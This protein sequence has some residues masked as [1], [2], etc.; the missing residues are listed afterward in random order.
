MARLDGKTALITGGG[1]GIGKATALLFS[2]EGA[3]V[4][5]MS[6]TA[7]RLDE[8]VAENPG[9]GEIK[10]YPGDVSVEEDVKRVVEAFYGDFGSVDILFNNAG[11]LEGGTVVTTSNEVWDRTI[12]INV[13]G[14]FLVSKHVVPLMAKHGGGSIINNSSVLGIV[15]ME[16]CVAYNASKGAVRQITRSMALDHAKDNIR[17]NS[18]CPGYIKTK[19]DPEFMGNPPDAEEQLDAI[20]AD[21]IP[22]VRRAE[23]E[24]VAHSVLYLAS[25]EARYVT[26]SDLVIDG[27]WTTL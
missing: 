24:E 21:M 7:E 3:N 2:A 9:P 27:G 22:L 15:G 4:G 13:K 1:E 23:A 5:I 26:G 11:I 12:D 6:R 20:A 18:V 25:D 10:A 17:T 19:M 16:G 14:V 8:V